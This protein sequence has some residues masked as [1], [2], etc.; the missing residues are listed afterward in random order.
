M[1]G[2]WGVKQLDILP[3]E[4]FIGFIF[5]VATVKMTLVALN[6]MHMKFE[7]LVVFSL[8]LSPVFF[9]ILLLSVVIFDVPAVG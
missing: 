6:F 8:A 3:Y 5:L 9:L 4:L 7:N 1:I 2:Q